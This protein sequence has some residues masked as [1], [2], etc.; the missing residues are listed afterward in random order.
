M[1]RK[2]PL[3]DISKTWLVMPPLALAL[4]AMIVVAVE[5]SVLINLIFE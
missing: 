3:E 2:W 1:K 5:R 4:I